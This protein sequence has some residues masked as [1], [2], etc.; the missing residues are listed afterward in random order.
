MRGLAKIGSLVVLGLLVSP[1]L[2][3]PP[4][5]D[6][7][8]VGTTEAGAS[9]AITISGAQATQYLYRGEDVA[10]NRSGARGKAF[11]MDVGTGHSAIQLNKAGKGQ[12][13]YSY[14]GSDGS[15]AS[16]TLA[17]Q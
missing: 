10:V 3:Q 2:A 8:W 17:Q 5:W 9:V 11:R 14:Q 7:T 12:V 6:G 13:R 16:A 1:A 15:T 4:A